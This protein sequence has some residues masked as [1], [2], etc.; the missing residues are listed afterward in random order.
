M[1]LLAARA[2]VAAVLAGPAEFG[3]AR[4]GRRCT[5]GLAQLGI[6]GEFEV[7][8]LA[9]TV[10]V[11]LPVED[12]QFAE[13]RAAGYRH[14]LPGRVDQVTNLLDGQALGQV[15]AAFEGDDQDV[16]GADRAAIAGDLV[17]AR[18]QC[19]AFREGVGRVEQGVAKIVFGHVWIRR[20]ENVRML[21]R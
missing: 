1:I 10:A 17:A 11:D 16:A 18:C 5:S 4:L 6:D 21:A 20:L 2:E 8:L 13:Y 7:Q 12:R 19:A 9:A 14:P 15:A 3:D